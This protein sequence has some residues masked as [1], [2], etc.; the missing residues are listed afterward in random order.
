MA[1]QTQLNKQAIETGRQIRKAVIA[2]L[3]PEEWLEGFTAEERLAGLAPE[4]V[5]ALMAQIE[6]YLRTH[7]IEKK[8]NS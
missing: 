7:N 1:H 3:T 5:I 6:I 2:R 8:M 4:G